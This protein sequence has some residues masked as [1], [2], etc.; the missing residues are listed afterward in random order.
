MS[1]TT[2]ALGIV[3]ALILFFGAIAVGRVFV[4]RLLDVRPS[5]NVKARETNTIQGRV[6]IRFQPGD[7][8][9]AGGEAGRSPGRPCSGGEISREFS[10]LDPGTVVTVK[11]E[12]GRIVATGELEQGV[13]GPGECSVP[14]SAKKVPRAKSYG[15][16]VSHRKEQRLSHKELEEKNLRADLSFGE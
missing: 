6:N 15:F 9:A 11:D 12:A 13:W 2:R 7:K 10:D 8:M 4:G 5:G 1:R 14:F 3:A 16:G